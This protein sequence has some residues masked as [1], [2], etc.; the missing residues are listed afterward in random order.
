MKNRIKHI[1]QQLLGYH[2]Y[3]FVFAL[4]IVATLKFQRKEKDFIYFVKLISDHGFLLDI[5]ANLGVMTYFL[6]SRKPN[7]IVYAF[8]PVPE[9]I[10]TLRKVIKWFHLKNVRV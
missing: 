7:S 1:L 2:N 8:E 5:G 3:L 9:N 10:A 4:W 6:A